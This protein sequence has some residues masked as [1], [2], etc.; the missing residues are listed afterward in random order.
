MFV[1]GVLNVIQT[2]G[3]QTEQEE[4]PFLAEAESSG[5]AVG[6]LGGWAGLVVTGFCQEHRPFHM[7]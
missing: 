4:S 7:E 6:F 5:K 3:E 2:A 1:S